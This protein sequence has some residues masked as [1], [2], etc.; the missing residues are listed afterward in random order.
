M[1]GWVKKALK[2]QPQD[3]SSGGDVRSYF[4]AVRAHYL[5]VLRRALQDATESGGQVF[6][7]AAPTVVG[8]EGEEVP[9]EELPHRWDILCMDEDGGSQPIMAVGDHDIDWESTAFEFGEFAARV[10]HLVWN[11]CV[12][13]GQ[14]S[15]PP[16]R[17]QLLHSWFQK[18]FNNSSG[19]DAPFTGVVH[20]MDIDESD[21]GEMLRV[22]IDLGSAPTDAL[23]ELLDVFDDMGCREGLVYTPEG[24]LEAP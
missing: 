16:A 12:V 19:D 6:V 18:W 22:Q 23:L 13:V 4:D 10:E 17:R 21:G 20:F 8:P 14:P 15:P 2:G 24:A 9:T 11:V 7:E 3:D 5:E 1:I